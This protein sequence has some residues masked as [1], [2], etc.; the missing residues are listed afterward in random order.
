MRKNSLNIY[1]DANKIVS[2][3]QLILLLSSSVSLF[4]LFLI[5]IVCVF[6]FY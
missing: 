5:R 1:S 3:I 4:E 2:N 6:F